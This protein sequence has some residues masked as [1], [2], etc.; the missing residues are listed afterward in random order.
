VE[1]YIKNNG[2]V[3]AFCNQK[4]GVGKT[5]TVYN[6]A[7]EF[8]RQ[9]KSVLLIDLDQQG[10]L[11]STVTD[12]NLVFE[13]SLFDVLTST[14]EAT[15]IDALVQTNWENVGIIPSGGAKMNQLL[16]EMNQTNSVGAE[17]VLKMVLDKCDV[18][19]DVV[20]IDCAPRID[21]L[22]TNALVASDAAIIVSQSQEYS[23]AGI[24]NL[25]DH[26]QNIKRIFN[27]NLDVLGI[28]LNQVKKNQS[29]EQVWLDKFKEWGNL[30]GVKVFEPVIPD[31]TAIKQAQ[32]LQVGLDK[33]S[34]TKDLI[35]TYTKYVKEITKEKNHG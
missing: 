12:S 3:I 18:D 27:P 23:F 24:Q 5:T 29:I 16:S 4:G 22:V 14:S 17:L 19:F 34:G 11:T 2:L 32:M 30:V 33:I 15:L 31:K 9:N 35:N 1:N 20:L 8:S 6:L 13:Y 21:K 26:I 7:R 10:N 25:Y 28:I